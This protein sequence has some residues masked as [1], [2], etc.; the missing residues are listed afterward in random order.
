MGALA[1]WIVV[2][3]YPCFRAYFQ[4]DD[5][6]WLQF[7]RDHSLLQA[8]LQPSPGGWTTPLANVVFWFQ[9]HL[10]GENA[11]W[12]YAFG[13]LLH[14]CNSILI[15]SITKLIWSDVWKA[16]LAALLFATYFGHYIEY[17]PVTWIAGFVQLLVSVFYLGAVSSFLAYLRDGHLRFL[18]LAVSLTLLALLTK[19]TA[20]S[21]MAILV[22][23]WLNACGSNRYPRRS[24]R[25]LL[26][27]G[28]LTMLYLLY[29]VPFQLSGKYLHEGQYSLGPHLLTNWQYL[30]NLVLPNLETGSLRTFF[31]SSG[32]GA[33]YRQ[34]WD[35]SLLIRVTIPFLLFLLYWKGEARIRYW[36][37]W[38]FLTYFPFIGFAGGWAGPYRYFYLP[39]VGFFALLSEGLWYVR[40]VIKQRASPFAMTAIWM[41]VIGLWCLLWIYPVRIWENQMLA[42]SQTRRW[43]IGE[44]RPL[45]QTGVA[46]TATVYL[47]GFPERFKDLAY[48]VPIM[49]GNDTVWGSSVPSPV[50]RILIVEYR[51]GSVRR[52]HTKE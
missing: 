5:Y 43:V 16:W 41:S 50:S 36:V 24:W 15:Y 1:A 28:I 40:T 39:A 46:P 45:D 6:L 42:N 51:D 38:I 27:F 52:I 9:F 18:I 30:A 23:T 33:Y 13:V 26:P 48:A 47:A 25:S 3:A 34:L 49:T 29:E 21:L 35:L 44:L 10:F 7:V 19:E 8:V 17:G 11:R 4:Y 32:F 2:L 20:L 31:S 14:G 12:Y 22:V 37:A